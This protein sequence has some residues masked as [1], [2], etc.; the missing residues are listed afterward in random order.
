MKDLLFC[1]ATTHTFALNYYQNL[2]SMKETEIN[3]IQDLHPILQ[4]IENLLAFIGKILSFVKQNIKITNNKVTKI[5]LVSD[6]TLYRLRQTGS[7]LYVYQ[8]GK[9]IY[10]FDD[11]L[12][13]I[14]S[15]KLISRKL[16]KQ[17]MLKNMHNYR[18]IYI[19]NIINKL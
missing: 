13:A 3:C 7:I 10:N 12:S 11:I 6:S 2:F 8:K 17:E 16:S 1:F 5:L 9:I 19:F 18:E 14:E 4:R 15:N